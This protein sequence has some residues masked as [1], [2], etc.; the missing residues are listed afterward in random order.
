MKKRSIILSLLILFACAVTMGQS[1]KQ[2]FEVP[3]RTTLFGTQVGNGMTVIQKD[4]GY[5]IILTATVQPTDNLQSVYTSGN[6]T[7]PKTP[8]LPEVT[9]T[10][11]T[12]TTLRRGTAI[13][14]RTHLWIRTN[15]GWRK[16]SFEF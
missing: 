9:G 16:I 13:I 2:H 14:T 1:Y 11:T 10:D 7:Y 5:S 3:T 4:S 8:P 6:F 12:S 15:T